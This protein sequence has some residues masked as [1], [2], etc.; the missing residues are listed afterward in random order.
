MVLLSKL[1]ELRIEK[2]ALSSVPPLIWLA[3]L[4]AAI[5]AV[6]SIVWRALAH[7]YMEYE[8]LAPFPE[9]AE[10]IGKERLKH[11]VTDPRRFERT[12]NVLYR[13][14]FRAAPWVIGPGL[15]LSWTLTALHLRTLL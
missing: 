2:R 15:L 10:Y 7:R 9:M 4:V 6:Y 11:C 3:F 12:D 13:W 1:V 8:I 14:L 5:C